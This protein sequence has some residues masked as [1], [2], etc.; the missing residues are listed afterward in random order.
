MRHIVG[1][2][3]PLSSS[4]GEGTTHTVSLAA[5]DS[6]RRS[7]KEEEDTAHTILANASPSWNSILHLVN[8]RSSKM[9][10]APMV[11][12]SLVIYIKNDVIYYYLPMYMSLQDFLEG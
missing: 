2:H 12:P 11:T 9:V 8:L 4:R 5:R 6:P 1:K 7:I 3:E 10:G